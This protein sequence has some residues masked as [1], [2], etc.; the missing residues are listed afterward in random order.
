MAHKKKVNKLKKQECESILNRLA[1]QT[2]NKYYQHVLKHY[3]NLI[4]K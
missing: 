2:E 4:G 1:N 3:N